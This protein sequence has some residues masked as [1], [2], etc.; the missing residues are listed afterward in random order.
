MEIQFFR[1]RH[2]RTGAVWAIMDRDFWPGRS[3]VSGSLIV[4]ELIVQG[5]PSFSEFCQFDYNRSLED[6]AGWVRGYIEACCSPVAL[7]Y[8][9]GCEGLG[10]HIHVATI[11][12]QNGFRWV[13]EPLGQSSNT[14]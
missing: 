4:G 10:G 5:H 6:A 11:S 3:I 1:V 2:P 8:D 9:P 13:V 12:P 7:K 14:G